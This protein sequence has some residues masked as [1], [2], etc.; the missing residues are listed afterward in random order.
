[1]CDHFFL[2]LMD[3]RE[4]RNRTLGVWA[5]VEKSRKRKR[6]AKYTKWTCFLLGSN[7]VIKVSKLFTKE[8]IKLYQEVYVCGIGRPT[9][10][11]HR[12]DNSSI[13]VPY[14]CHHVPKF[15]NCRRCCFEITWSWN[16]RQLLCCPSILLHKIIF[17]IYHVT[18]CL[19]RGNGLKSETVELLV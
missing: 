2:Y 1:M 7:P 14:P 8:T 19:C 11:M 9:E 16:S 10:L 6:Q 4:K 17:Q 12:L 5:V 13:D 18:K 15:V 3:A